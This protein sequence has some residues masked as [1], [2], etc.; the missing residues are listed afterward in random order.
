MLNHETI[1]RPA[2]ANRLFKPG[3]ALRIVL[4]IV[5]ILYVAG[6]TALQW[7]SFSGQRAEVAA[8]RR[9]EPP[10]TVGPTSFDIVGQA[11]ENA[12]AV[13]RPALARVAMMETPQSRMVPIAQR[14][15]IRAMQIGI[16]AF[17]AFV[18]TV[19]RSSSHRPRHARS[20]FRTRVFSGRA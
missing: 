12:D 15:A 5:T 4:A 3:T 19:R 7:M 9:L 10:V 2:A 11:S 6:P 16:A 17:L 1:A 18:I 13:L 8:I 14:T 20:G